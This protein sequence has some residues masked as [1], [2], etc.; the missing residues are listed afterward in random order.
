MPKWN[1]IDVDDRFKYFWA[2][3]IILLVFI[4]FYCASAIALARSLCAEG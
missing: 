2:V 1:K 4:L 3:F